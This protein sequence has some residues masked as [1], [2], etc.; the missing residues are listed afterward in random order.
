[1]RGLAAGVILSLGAAGVAAAEG[2][3]LM[4]PVAECA[5]LESLV[6]FGLI[7]GG[8]GGD[9]SEL[10]A[11]VE[12]GD[13]G[14]CLEWLESYGYP[15]LYDADCVEAFALMS[16]NGLPEWLAGE[17]PTYITEILAPHGPEICANMLFDLTA[18]Q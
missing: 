17:E 15:G 5:A 7:D 16:F 1:M 9:T 13:P 2:W 10:S 18:G 8:E 11:V 3:G 4:S 14:L 12:A 6:V